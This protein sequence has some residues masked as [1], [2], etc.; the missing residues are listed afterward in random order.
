MNRE[1]KEDMFFKILAY[2]LLGVFSIMALY[3]FIYAISASISGKVPF[4]RGE[5]LLFPK[6]ITFA[7]YGEIFKDKTF[8]ISYTNT[9][10]YTFFGTL[11]SMFVSTTGAFVLAKRET[12]FRRHLNFGLV[13]TMW[14]VPGMVPLY[15]NYISLGM[16]NRWGMV[17]AFGVQAYNVILLRNYFEAIPKEIEEAAVI[18][19]ANEIQILTKVYI[20]MSKAAM[21]TVG[22]FYAVSRWNGYFWARVLLRDSA[23]QPLQVYLRLK[24][25]QIEELMAEVG[26]MAGVEYAADSLVYA[27]LVCSIIPVLILY[28]YIQKYFAK[29]V[30]MG[31]VKG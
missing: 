23:D 11:W 22:L 5:I 20:P 30:N 6:E 12:L 27:M 17:F 26:I 4:E 14:F 3:P 31:G 1:S 8:W 10:F 19:G 9:L 2:T 13:F 28:P 25:E 7:A 29:G 24:I 18:D 21:A 16:D 15:L